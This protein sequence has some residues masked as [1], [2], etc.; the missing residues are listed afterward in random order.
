M[1]SSL[2]QF[3][4]IRFTFYRPAL[5]ESFLE[6]PPGI[7]TCPLM[8]ACWCHMATCLALGGAICRS[9]SIVLDFGQFWLMHHFRNFR[10]R[11]SCAICAWSRHA[12]PFALKQI[13]SNAL[14]A[15]GER[16]K[17]MH[18]CSKICSLKSIM[19]LADHAWCKRVFW[20]FCPMHHWNADTS[21][22]TNWSFG[23]LLFLSS[24]AQHRLPYHLV[25]KWPAGF[26]ISCFWLCGSIFLGSH[27]C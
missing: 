7:F 12:W 1:Q 4:L 21:C 5:F 9:R 10:G 8:W 20:S 25:F 18:S 14:E 3:S 2:V 16:N 17:S 13:V 26:D 11:T 23:T 24:T 15:V 19:L 22:M 6:L 27:G